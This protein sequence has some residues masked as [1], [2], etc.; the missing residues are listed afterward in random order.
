MKVHH[1]N[2]CTMCPFG[3]LFT[4][5]EMIVHALL[6]ETDK[7]GLVLVDTGFGLDDMR[8]AVTR[9]GRSFVM[10]MKPTLGE[11]H[12]AIR[13]IERLGY[14]AKDVRHLACTHLDV[15]H[16]GGIPD[17]PDAKVH[18]HVRERDAAL[19]RSTFK[20]RERYRPVHFAH[21]PKWET[22]EEDGEKWFG[23][24]SVRAIADDVLFIPLFG[25]T[26]GHCAIAVRAPAGTD[27]EWILHCGDAY[28]F[29]CEMDEKPS[30]PAGIAGFQTFIAMD[31]AARRANQRRLRALKKEEGSRI[32]MFSAHSSH[33]Y[34]AL[35]GSRT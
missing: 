24:D 8:Q 9:L 15:D 25:H 19:T 34:R 1:L 17:F 3:G 13:Q 35:T 22:H 6:V 18:V 30:C 21:S 31:D 29:H 26:R 20:E 27:V 10:G 2:L 4:R 11:E 32:R 23:F 12:T 16:A 33:E 28:F 7:D 5:G 14:F